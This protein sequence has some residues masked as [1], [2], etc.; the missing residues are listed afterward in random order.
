MPEP[1][2]A[3]ATGCKAAASPIWSAGRIGFLMAYSSRLLLLLWWWLSGD[4]AS[5]PRRK[6]LLKRLRYGVVRVRG[7]KHVLGEIDLHAVPLP[8][9]DRGRDLHEAVQ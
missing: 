5:L 8:N 2:C 7:Q 3:C 1:N 4:S 9:R 6:S